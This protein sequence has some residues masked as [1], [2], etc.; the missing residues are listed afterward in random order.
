MLLILWGENVNYKMLL[1]QSDEKR[2]QIGS[3]GR[4]SVCEMSLQTVP[5]QA[6]KW[7]RCWHVLEAARGTM[8]LV[9]VARMKKVRLMRSGGAR[10]TRDA[11]ISSLSPLSLPGTQKRILWVLGELRW[12]N[13]VKEAFGLLFHGCIAYKSYKVQNDQMGIFFS[14]SHQYI[15]VY[16]PL[17]SFSILHLPHLS[18]FFLFLSS[19]SSFSSSSSLSTHLTSISNCMPRI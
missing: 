2:I 9:M 18:S 4:A 16:Q 17:S 11:H 6:L 8:W 7:A 13:R 15:N 3:G 10:V 19:S 1:L 5:D 14:L 12:G